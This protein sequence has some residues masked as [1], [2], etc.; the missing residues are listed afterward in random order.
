MKL[1]LD[2]INKYKK[3]KREDVLSLAAERKSII[4]EQKKKNDELE[5]KIKE[6]E[7]KNREIYSK[8]LEYG[9]EKKKLENR[10]KE[11]IKEIKRMKDL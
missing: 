8:T 2:L 6:L 7:E 5:I 4:D 11:P 1:E 9:E 3:E 10:G